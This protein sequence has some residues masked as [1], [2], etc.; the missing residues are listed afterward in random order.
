MHMLSTCIPS[1]KDK[2]FLNV[3]ITGWFIQLEASRKLLTWED[4]AQSAAATKVV[5]WVRWSLD[6]THSQRRI[7]ISASC[8]RKEWGWYRHSSSP[9]Q[10]PSAVSLPSHTH[11][12]TFLSDVNGGRGRPLYM[13]KVTG[14][15]ERCSYIK[16][17]WM[18]DSFHRD[19]TLD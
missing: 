17:E 3:K 5:R 10:V 4:N 1:P 18:G 16:D 7:G 19:V 6:L 12:H 8:E 2:V 11:T 9:S 14:F 13:S 15:L